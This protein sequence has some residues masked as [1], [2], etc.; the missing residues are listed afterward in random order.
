MSWLLIVFGVVGTV[1]LAL[2]CGLIDR[3]PPPIPRR[4]P[5]RYGRRS[6]L[7][8]VDLNDQRRI[9]RMTAVHALFARPKSTSKCKG[10]GVTRFSRHGPA[11][12]CHCS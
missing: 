1:S 8:A 9:F 7:H 6:D 12:H 4:R 2:G 10:V 5:D 3:S 11:K